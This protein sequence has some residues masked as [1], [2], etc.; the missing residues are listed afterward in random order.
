[1]TYDVYVF[2]Y[3]GDTAIAAGESPEDAV[4]AFFQSFERMD[5]DKVQAEFQRIM[6]RDAAKPLAN[7]IER[8]P[9]LTSTRRG[10]ITWHI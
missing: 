4:L 1:M 7:V 2:F 10:Y 3:D 5:Q 9:A 8:L 6:D